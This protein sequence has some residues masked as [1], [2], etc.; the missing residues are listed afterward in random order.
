MLKALVFSIV[1]LPFFNVFKYRIC[2]VDIL[3]DFGSINVFISVRMPFK[4]LRTI[5]LLYFSKRNVR[6]NLKD[7]IIILKHY[8]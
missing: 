4:R 2:F 6:F 7:L 1:S 8:F 3:H 5:R